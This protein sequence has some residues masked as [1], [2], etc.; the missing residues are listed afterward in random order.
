MLYSNAMASQVCPWCKRHIPNKHWVGH[1]RMHR[2]KGDTAIQF[3]DL[4]EEEDSK[5]LFGGIRLESRRGSLVTL[6][7]VCA[8]CGGQRS[9]L[10][11]YQKS[12]RG[13]V[14]ICARCKPRVFNR[15][16]G[17][18]DAWSTV[19]QRERRSGP[20]DLPLA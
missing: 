11:L 6:P 18:A 13:Q 19:V 15:S 1:L 17:P 7:G 9:R 14:Y 16:H 3:P 5:P 2:R 10:W 8:E 20:D 4:P 12:N